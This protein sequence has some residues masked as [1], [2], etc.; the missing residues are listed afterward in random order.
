MHSLSAAAIRHIE[1]QKGE[2]KPVQI[3]VTMLNSRASFSSTR[4]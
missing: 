2:L 1:I 4:C 3:A